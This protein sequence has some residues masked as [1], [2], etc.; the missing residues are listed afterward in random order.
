MSREA[1]LAA[2]EERYRVSHQEREQLSEKLTESEKY[3]G[4]MMSIL[5]EMVYS[6]SYYSYS[7]YSYYHYY[8]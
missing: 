6:Y 2:L 7:Y 4:T 5:A 8:H 1:Q 3:R